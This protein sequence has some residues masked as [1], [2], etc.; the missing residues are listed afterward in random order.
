MITK[1]AVVV[2]GCVD[3]PDLV[4]IAEQRRLNLLGNGHAA[5]NGAHLR[6]RRPGDLV[7]ADEIGAAEL[8]RLISLGVCK[9]AP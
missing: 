5:R 2:R 8:E 9:E 4:A 7:T 6:R 3:I 1:S